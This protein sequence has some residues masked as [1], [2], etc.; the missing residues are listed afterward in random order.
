[1]QTVV[2]TKEQDNPTSAECIQQ[3]EELR[4]SFITPID[5]VRKEPSSHV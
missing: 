2:I 5:I 4:K 1:M 3:L